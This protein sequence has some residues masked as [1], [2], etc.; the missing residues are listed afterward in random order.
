MGLSGSGIL[1]LWRLTSGSGWGW[2]L[3]YMGYMNPLYSIVIA[4]IFN[5]IGD[6]FLFY[7]GKYHKKDIS[8]IL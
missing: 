5:Y 4:V 1:L 6:M 3:S 7:L 8:T 2:S